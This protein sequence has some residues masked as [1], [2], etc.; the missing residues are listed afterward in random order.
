MDIIRYRL[1]LMIL[2]VLF[3]ECSLYISKIHWLA[4]FEVLRE[5]LSLYLENVLHYFEFQVSTLHILTHLT[6]SC[7]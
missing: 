6:E 5:R 7:T 3:M 4:Y 2:I 1:E